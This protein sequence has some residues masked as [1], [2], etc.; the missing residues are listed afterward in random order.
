MRIWL[1]SLISQ[2][3]KRADVSLK[4]Y[5]I[6]IQLLLDLENY[7]KIYFILNVDSRFI[8]EI[9]KFIKSVMKNRKF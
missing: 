4:W 9:C 5:K 7:T 8:A 2:F 1:I 3:V 6:G